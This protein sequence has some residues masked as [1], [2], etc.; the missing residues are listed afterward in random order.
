MNI[1]TSRFEPHPPVRD[2]MTLVGRAD[3]T[4]V[5]V[6]TGHG[7][8]GFPAV[9][10]QIQPSPPDRATAAHLHPDEAR[11]VAEQLLRAAAAN[12]PQSPPPP[13]AD[14]AGPRRSA[15][16]AGRSA[17][18]AERGAGHAGRGAGHAVLAQEG[19]T[20]AALHRALAVVPARARLTDFVADAEVVLIFDPT[21]PDSDRAGGAEF[22]GG[23]DSA[24]SALSRPDAPGRARR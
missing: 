19:V 15:G 9:L 4:A 20:A 17:D 1:D 24:E 22:A 16:H 2:A 3:G 18:H 12:E 10:L 11:Q 13:D 6:G 21:G 14:R 23:G 5:T 8:N 7:G